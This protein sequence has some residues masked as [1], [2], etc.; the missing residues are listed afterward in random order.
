MMAA[1]IDVFTKSSDIILDLTALQVFRIFAHRYVNYFILEIFLIIRLILFL[2]EYIN[3]VGIEVMVLKLS[4]LF[5][6]WRLEVFCNEVARSTLHSLQLSEVHSPSPPYT[7]FRPSPSP[8]ALVPL[9]LPCP[10]SSAPI[11]FGGRPPLFLINS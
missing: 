2:F 10:S 9:P 7:F 5:F 3:F 4:R 8:S 11:L 1:R 6:N